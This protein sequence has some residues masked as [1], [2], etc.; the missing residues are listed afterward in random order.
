MTGTC[1]CP[2]GVGG[3]HCEDGGCLWSGRGLHLSAVPPLSVSLPRGRGGEDTEE[4]LSFEFAA[5]SGACVVADGEDV[6]EKQHFWNGFSRQGVSSPFL[7]AF[8]ECCMMGGWDLQ[9][10]S[11]PGL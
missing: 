8:K 6:A 3:A 10:G 1:R 9:K 7:E 11:L 2:P 5:F 4:A